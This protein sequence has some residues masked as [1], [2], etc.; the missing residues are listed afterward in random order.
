MNFSLSIYIVGWYIQLKFSIQYALKK[1]HS[2]CMACGKTEVE[3]VLDDDGDIPIARGR[4]K[5]LE[6]SERMATLQALLSH[7]K[8]KIKHG[9]VGLVSKQL[10]SL[11]VSIIWK[12]GRESVGDGGGAMV[13]L[14]QMKKRGRKL[15]DYSQQIA[16]LSNIPLSDRTGFRSS[17]DPNDPPPQHCEEWS[18]PAPFLCCQA[19]AE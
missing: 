6:N 2:F 10:S 11:T 18:S 4:G 8:S 3:T 9:A 13:V 19:C 15:K 16:N 14:Y 12:R 7:K 5:L 1:P 17:S